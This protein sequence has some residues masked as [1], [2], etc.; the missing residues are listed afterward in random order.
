MLV[1]A[2]Y[3]LLFFILFLICQYH[4]ILI[5]VSSLNFIYYIIFYITFNI[6]LNRMSQI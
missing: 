2:L 1:D 4:I 6:E 5:V 3:S